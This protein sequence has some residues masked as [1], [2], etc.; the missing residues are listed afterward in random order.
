MSDL[1]PQI[2]MQLRLGLHRHSQA[3]PNGDWLR[4]NDDL[5][6]LRRLAMNWH[7]ETFG[8]GNEMAAAYLDAEF[9]DAQAIP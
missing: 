9:E 2:A 1:R 8:M 6:K 5:G 7:L 4:V 3:F